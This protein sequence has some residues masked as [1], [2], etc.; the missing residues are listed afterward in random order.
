LNKETIKFGLLVFLGL[1]LATA[2]IAW[3][4]GGKWKLPSKI[5]IPAVVPQEEALPKISLAFEP[6]EKAVYQGETFTLDVLIRGEEEIV[7][8]D[9]YFSYNPQA[10]EI[11]KVSPGN[12]FADAQE[13]SKEIDANEG[14][15]FYA[16][17]S[18]TP[19]AGEDILV[20]LTFKGK[21]G[22]SQGL[23]T[24]DEKTQIAI[25]K[26]ERVDLEL[27]DPGKYSILELAE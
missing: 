9:L 14:K 8:A 18:L 22:G 19:K 1:I 23:I 10:T 3:S 2:C 7:G 21:L 27:P 12:F 13:L 25:E 17:T 11:I 5:K 16:L 20:S 24:I 26:E 4:L 6:K 15:I